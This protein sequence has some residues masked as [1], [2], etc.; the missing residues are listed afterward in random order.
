MSEICTEDM[1]HKVV[2]GFLS[3]SSSHVPFIKSDFWPWLFSATYVCLRHA[4][5]NALAP[6]SCAADVTKILHGN[7]KQTHSSLATCHLKTKMM[8]LYRWCEA[9]FK[10]Y[11]NEHGGSLCIWHTQETEMKSF[12]NLVLSHFN[13]QFC[14]KVII[15]NPTVQNISQTQIRNWSLVLSSF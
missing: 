1:E 13:L 15:K 8:I 10:Q 3:P 7:Q 6:P 4:A 14:S 12:S 9:R 5:G 11:A 2:F